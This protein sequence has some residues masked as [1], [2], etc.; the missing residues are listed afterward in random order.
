MAGLVLAFGLFFTY[1]C[2]TPGGTLNQ[3]RKSL[4]SDNYDDA[5]QAVNN[6]LSEEPNNAE[7][8]FLK[9]SILRS[10]A[11]SNNPGQ[12]QQLY[13]QMRESLLQARK[14]YRQQ[15]SLSDNLRDINNMLG[16]SWS[17]EQTQ[18]QNLVNGDSLDNSEPMNLALQHFD[19]AITIL[20]DTALSYRWKA[21]S[22][23]QLGRVDEAV[24]ALEAAHARMDQPSAKTLEQL[25]FLYLKNNQTDRA[26]TLYQQAEKDFKGNTNLLRGLANAYIRLDKHQQ[27]LPLVEK[28]VNQNPGDSDYRLTYGSELYALFS[29]KVDSLINPPVHAATDKDSAASEE[30]PGLTDINKKLVPLLQRAEFQYQKADSLN[31]HDIHTAFST[32]MFYKNAAARFM[33]I[34]PILNEEEQPRIQDRI[35]DYLNKSIPYLDRAARKGIDNSDYWN[36][37]YEVYKALGM[38]DEAQQARKKTN[39]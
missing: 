37:L 1:S 3:A 34:K 17:E 2:S 22:L 16:E 25:A 13:K 32:G 6:T 39:L 28:L 8:Y 14:L 35:D 9:G 31:G 18:G 12:R 4:S 26:L 10:K 5:L 38:R 36:Q 24:E 23:Y 15:D 11:R 7:A 33:Q 27:A 30:R 29:Q 21:R 20:P 19:N